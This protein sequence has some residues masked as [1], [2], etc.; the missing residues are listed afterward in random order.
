MAALY[1]V[2]II[3]FWSLR[4]KL[5]VLKRY[6][7]LFASD[8]RKPWKIFRVIKLTCIINAIILIKYSFYESHGERDS[9]VCDAR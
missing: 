4:E 7:D 8:E 3:I 2:Y 5:S 6:T 9:V 1:S